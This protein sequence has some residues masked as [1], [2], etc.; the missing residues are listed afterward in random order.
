MKGNWGFFHLGLP[1]LR[2]GYDVQFGQILLRDKSVRAIE[3]EYCATF[4]HEYVHFLQSVLFRSCQIRAL[5]WHHFGGNGAECEMML[6][7]QEANGN[8][9]FAF[10]WWA[11][12]G[13]MG[14]TVK[15]TRSSVYLTV[16]KA[17]FRHPK[18]A[19]VLAREFWK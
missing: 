12:F 16:A 4:V 15:A 13:W 17:A 19:W 2:M 9:S 1:Y 3:E 18:E 5:A 14:E 8:Q 11:L 10:W 7:C 6:A